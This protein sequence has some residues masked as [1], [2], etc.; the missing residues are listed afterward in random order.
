MKISYSLILSLLSLHCFADS[1]FDPNNNQLS[2]PFVRY[3]GQTYNAN[4]IFEPPNKLRLNSATLQTKIIPSAGL[5][6]VYKDLSFHLS[7][8]QV[9][10]TQYSLDANYLGDNLFQLEN[11]FKTQATPR[12]R[13]QFNTPFFAGSGICAQCHN[14]LTD[15]K[16]NDVS[17][18][19]AW[20]TSMM[21]NA[22]R[23]PFWQAKVKSEL[24]R[25][26]QLAKVIQD[27]C[28]RCHAPMANETARKN[29][30][31][32]QAIFG[33]GLLNSHNP[34]Y[35]LSSSGVSCSLCHQISPNAPFGTVAGYSGNFAI[36]VATTKK[37]RPIYG[38]YKEVFTQPMRNFVS[39]T[40]TFSEHIKSSELCASCHDLSTPYT[41]ENGTVLS[42]NTEDEFPEQMP[43]SEWKHSQF[44]GTKSC[45]QCHMERSNGVV[46]ASRPG[47]TVK[48]DDFAQHSFLGANRLMLKI[49]EDYLRHK[50]NLLE[51]LIVKCIIFGAYLQKMYN[52]ID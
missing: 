32:V 48:R 26:P 43:Y 34:Y 16:G 50:M 37:D 41:D 4:L 25:T 15:E 27:K 36:D 24:N 42:T 35:D 11:L 14:D 28:T 23:D 49:L 2:I 38:P 52:I 31:S 5:V 21:A 3:Q 33:D 1:S 9:G 30:D 39:F 51:M 40:P 7:T 46:I 12:G 18:E 17:I 19:T 10:E 45:Q 47:N 13:M 20:K 29:K 6:P 8:I 44:S 22:T